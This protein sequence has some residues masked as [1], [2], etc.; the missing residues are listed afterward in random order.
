MLA[1]FQRNSSTTTKWSLKYS[2][3]T[4]IAVY[5]VTKKKLNRVNNLDIDGMHYREKKTKLENKFEF[6]YL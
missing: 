5:I 3:F 6:D 1:D 2:N 4:V